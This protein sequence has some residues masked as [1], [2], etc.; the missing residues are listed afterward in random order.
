M[1]YPATGPMTEPSTLVNE[2]ARDS[3]ALFHWKLRSSTT[4]QI[5]IPWNK[6]TV[7]ITITRAAMPASHQP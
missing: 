3:W 4:N 6:G 2:K 5:G 1:R 7:P